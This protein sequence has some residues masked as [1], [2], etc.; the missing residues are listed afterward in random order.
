M[1]NFI[2]FVNEQ[3]NRE[4]Q[5]PHRHDCHDPPYTAGMG[6][7]DDRSP[8]RR[9]P[10]VARSGPPRGTTP[11]QVGRQRGGEDVRHFR[12]EPSRPALSLLHCL[13][14]LRCHL[15]A[16]SFHAFAS[17]CHPVPTIGCR[18]N[19]LFEVDRELGCVGTADFAKQRLD[20]GEDADVLS[21]VLNLNFHLR[22]KTRERMC[23]CQRPPQL[24]NFL[25]FSGT[26]QP[27]GEARGKD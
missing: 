19:Q 23:V 3:L 10:A 26:N 20:F 16:H 12:T 15:T 14:L 8:P 5:S 25:R 2:S 13:R 11:A 21:A 9:L 1:Q 6:F 7:L 17:F 22:A 27:S 24:F 18:V 4:E